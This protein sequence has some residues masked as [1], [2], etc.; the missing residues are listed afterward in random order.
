MS[1]TITATVQ[2]ENTIGT[3]AWVIKTVEIHHTKNKAGE[4][5]PNGRTYR[6][7]KIAFGAQITLDGYKPGDLI[8]V[9]GSESTT[10]QITRDGQKYHNLVIKATEIKPFQKAN[11]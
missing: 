2:V 4:W 8:T 7:I 5:V 10:A 3:P 1:N 6:D 9:T 11:Q